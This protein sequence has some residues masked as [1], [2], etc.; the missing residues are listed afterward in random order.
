MEDFLERLKRREKEKRQK[1]SGPLRGFLLVI[2]CA[3]LFF[4]FIIEL[5]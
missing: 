3:L 5:V 2:L 1:E 4:V